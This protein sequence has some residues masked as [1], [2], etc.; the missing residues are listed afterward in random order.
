L[1]YVFFMPDG[2]L[3]FYTSAEVAAMLRLHLQVVQ[4][5]LQAGEIP[6]Y[7]IGR[8]WRVERGQ[9]LTWLER[10]SNQR[11]RPLTD[12]WFDEAGRLRSL[13]AQRAKRRAVLVRVA[14]CFEV[15][16]PYTEPEVNEVLARIFDD[17]A[18][19]RRELVGAELLTRERGTYRRPAAGASS[20]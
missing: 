8:E 15:G 16:R 13:P 3:Q 9:L 20:V 14:E 10:Y 5:K 4:R 18:T 11:E 12:R 19:L 6:A 1:L 17:V 2:V 7:R